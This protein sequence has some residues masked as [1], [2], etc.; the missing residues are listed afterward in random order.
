[1]L[2]RTDEG[3]S[4]AELACASHD[5]YIHASLL[6]PGTGVTWETRYNAGST[7]VLRVEPVGLWDKPTGDAGL[8][9]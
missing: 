5:L 8:L 3:D 4:P 9:P 2:A 1:M 7:S 6:S